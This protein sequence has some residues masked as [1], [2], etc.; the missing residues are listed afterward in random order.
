MGKAIQTKPACMT[1]DEF[2][3]WREA[4]VDASQMVNRGRDYTLGLRPCHDCSREF[5][6]EMQAEDRCDGVPGRYRDFTRD[7]VNRYNRLCAQRK[8]AAA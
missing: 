4:A 6:A 5:A 1:D 8:R 7:E 3:S 2:E